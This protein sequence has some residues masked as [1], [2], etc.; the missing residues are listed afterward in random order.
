MQRNK[1]FG[2]IATE[3]GFN[4]FVGGNGGSKPRHSEILIKDCPIEKVIPY[5]DRYLMFYI[6]TADRLQRTAR[7]IENLPGGIK[8]LRQVVI[9]DSLGIGAEL[10]R[11]VCGR[12]SL[13][14]RES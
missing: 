11:Q 8:Y 14:E 2:L 4:I 3:N 9:D 13:G 10:E 6:R 5:I 12:H 1:D 7:W